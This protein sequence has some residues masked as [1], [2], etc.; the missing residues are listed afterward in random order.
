MSRFLLRAPRAQF[1]RGPPGVITGL[2]SEVAP[3]AKEAGVSL[4]PL[5][6]ISGCVLLGWVGGPAFPK[7]QQYRASVRK[8]SRDEAGGPE[9]DSPELLAEVQN[10]FYHMLPLEV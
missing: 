4:R 10:S 8:V 9:P 1:H 3:L 5:P 7:C 6:F 2:T